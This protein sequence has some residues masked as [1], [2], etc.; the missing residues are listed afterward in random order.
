MQSVEGLSAG[1]VRLIVGTKGLTSHLN[2]PRKPVQAWLSL[3]IIAN[4]LDSHCRPIKLK[5]NRA[6]RMDSVDPLID[7]VP[8]HDAT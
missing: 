5:V 8:A 6:I 7:G 1:S 3:D 2:A 4:R